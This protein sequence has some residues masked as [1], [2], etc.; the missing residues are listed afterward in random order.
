MNITAP[1]YGSVDAVREFA[2]PEEWSDNLKEQGA[3]QLVDLL[4]DEGECA[5]EF[6]PQGVQSGERNEGI[7]VLNKCSAEKL[8]NALLDWVADYD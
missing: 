5:I 8:G 1:T 4:D 6:H 2:G 3:I 7:L